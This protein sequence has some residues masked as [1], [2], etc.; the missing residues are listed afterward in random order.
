M[1]WAAYKHRTLLPALIAIKESEKA[2]DLRGAELR[3]IAPTVEGV[4]LHA[5]RPLKDGDIALYADIEIIGPDPYFKLEGGVAL[6]VGFGGKAVPVKGLEQLSEIVIGML[7]YSR[8]F[9]GE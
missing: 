2:L 7:D 1:W 3:H 9:L 4:V 5:G 6:D 8:R